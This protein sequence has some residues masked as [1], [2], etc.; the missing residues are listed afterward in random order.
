LEHAS[1]L[2]TATARGFPG[3]FDAV[4]F[5]YTMTRQRAWEVSMAKTIDKDTLPLNSPP[6][7]LRDRVYNLLRK[8]LREGEI[9]PNQHLGEHSL[10][11]EL[12]VSRT[13]VREALALLMR[14]GLLV[15][16]SKGLMLPELSI[17]DIQQ[18]YQIR[19]LLEPAGMKETARHATKQQIAALRQAVKSQAAAQKV[20]DV[21]GFLAA[22]AQFRDAALASIPSHRLRRVIELH[23]DH[24]QFMRNAT[25]VDPAVR[26]TVLQ[27]LTGILSAIV[28]RDVERAGA[29]T[30]KHLTVGEQVINQMYAGIARTPVLGPLSRNP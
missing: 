17:D 27:G 12:R 19:K 26:D 8:A 23:E 29:L 16:T 20:G 4:A 13:P 10:A 9:R 14:D 22:N 25:M 5:T 1:I 11:K 18:I 24:V 28:E 2:F 15:G 21:R 3:R 7:A 6:G 30:L